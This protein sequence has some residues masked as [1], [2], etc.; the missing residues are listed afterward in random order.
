MVDPGEEVTKPRPEPEPT[1]VIDELRRERLRQRL[2]DVSRRDIQIGRYTI[3]NVLG[4]GGLGTVYLAA[5]PTLNREVA[6]KVLHATD[7]TAP[8]DGSLLHE[9]TALARLR[10]P[11]V[12]SVYELVLSGHTTAVAMELVRGKTVRAWLDEDAPTTDEIVGAFIDAA[13]GLAAAHECGLVHRDFKPANAMRSLDGRIQ[14][15]DFGLAQDVPIDAHRT[16]V[17]NGGV[18]SSGGF[19]PGGYVV[20]TPRYMAPEQHRGE[21]TTPASDVFALC[22]S[23]AEALGS[24]MPSATALVTDKTEGR[25]EV[26]SSVPSRLRAVLRRGLAP[27]PN[28]RY[29]DAGQLRVALTEATRP[30][31][32]AWFAAAVALV[33]VGSVAMTAVALQPPACDPDQPLWTPQRAAEYAE[34]W[35]VEAKPLRAAAWAAMHQRLDTY[36]AD[37]ATY[38]DQVCQ[39]ELRARAAPLACIDDLRGRVA[40]VLT[41]WVEAGA[42]PVFP[43]AALSND[44]P[45][46]AEYCD[47]DFGDDPAAALFGAVELR[48]R[49]MLSGGASQAARDFVTDAIA[50]A[51]DAGVDAARARMLAIAA[52]A[53]LQLG[54]SRAQWQATL[55]EALASAEASGDPSTRVRVLA[56]SITVLGIH[57]QQV[58]EAERYIA[59]ASAL[60]ERSAVSA[61]SRF[62]FDISVAQFRHSQGQVQEAASVYRS[63]LQS[64]AREPGT[65]RLTLLALLAGVLVDL[66]EHAEAERLIAEARRIDSQLTGSASQLTGYL[67]NIAGHIAVDNGDYGQAVAQYEAAAELAASFP[68]RD[69]GSVVLNNLGKALAKLNPR[70]GAEVLARAVALSEAAVGPDHPQSISA[71]RALAFAELGFDPASAATHA[72]ELLRRIERSDP[73]GT[74]GQSITTEALLLVALARSETDVLESRYDDVSARLAASGQTLRPRERASGHGLLADYC[75]RTGDYACARFHLRAA[76]EIFDEL[77]VS[78]AADQATTRANELPSA[79]DNGDRGQRLRRFRG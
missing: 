57:L 39:R 54:V 29:A 32:G 71:F 64:H 17:G 33:A 26:P 40:V 35:D 77:G 62:T 18:A 75:E 46:P 50:E 48:A 6:L 73:G 47:H 30:R 38:H 9:A 21:T 10:H 45:P 51:E 15:V 28:D 69:G 59:Q 14:V 61:R 63:A 12:V 36:A 2:F 74:T 42:D 60:L 49:S 65:D 20:G 70:R 52:R 55:T 5:D 19:A 66:G 23:L 56:T 44:L 31:R 27:E 3:L 16:E 67:H 72:T 58:Q 34:A 37:L 24:T 4:K 76:A 41:P 68:T 13:R 79:D 78:G 8:A 43:A 7:E 11:N 1:E 53:E 22:M 25:I